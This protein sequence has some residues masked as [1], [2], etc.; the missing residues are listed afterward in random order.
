MIWNTHTVVGKCRFCF[1]FFHIWNRQCDKHSLY[2][3]KQSKWIDPMDIWKWMCQQTNTTRKK[4]THTHTYIV[5]RYRKPKKN[6]CFG[7]WFSCVLYM[8]GINYANQNQSTQF[9]LF[10]NILATVQECFIEHSRNT[11]IFI[12]HTHTLD[13]CGSKHLNRLN[14]KNRCFYW[15]SHN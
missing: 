14:Y 3:C 6:R 8:V 15:H 10:L 12:V 2:E 11:S 5:N 9:K 13:H 1:H 7:H 4:D